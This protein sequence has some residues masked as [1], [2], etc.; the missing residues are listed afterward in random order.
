M[1]YGADFCG[2]GEPDQYGVWGM[3]SKAI[4][5]KLCD[6]LGDKFQLDFIISI[7]SLARTEQDFLVCR[8]LFQTV[9]NPLFIAECDMVIAILNMNKNNLDAAEF[10]NKMH[11]ELR[12]E[13]GDPDGIGFALH[14]AGTIALCRGKY[15]EAIELVNQSLNYFES[16]GNQDLIGYTRDIMR[17]SE[18][19]QGNYHKAIEQIEMDLDQGQALGNSFLLLDTLSYR[20]YIALIRKEYEQA[21]LNS[22]K[23]LEIANDLA[24][25][26]RKMPLYVLGR[27]ALSRGDYPQ[28]REYL[29]KAQTKTR[30]SHILEFD[31][32]AIQALGV[33]AA[34]QGQE[35]RSAVIF[36][37]QEA[38][39]GYLLNLISPVERDEYQQALA[40]ARVALGEEAFTA[41]WEEGRS[42]TEEQIREYATEFP[43]ENTIAKYMQ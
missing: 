24:A 7:F 37:A 18:I 34:A 6:E 28:A 29:L 16:V 3:E 30:L 4:F 1:S 26:M 22:Q 14:L 17:V 31:Y 8:Q 20:G 40:A 13:M 38:L 43:K 36:G 12:R 33:L 5:Q 15:S 10:Y 25:P 35:R 2:F 42:M 11:L 39:C 41:A 21:V 32:H 19:A 27:V 23:A 9:N